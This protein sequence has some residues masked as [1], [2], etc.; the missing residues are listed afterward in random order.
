MHAEEIS[1]INGAD[2]KK[3]SHVLRFL[4]TQHWF[5]EVAPDTFAHNMLSS[6]IDTGKN[7]TD[8]FA[9]TK[10]KGTS[11]L[12]ALV[13]FWADEGVKAGSYFTE[14]LVDP[15][16]SHSEE[17]NEAALQ[18]G[19]GTSKSMWEYYD[20]PEGRVRGDRFD[21]FMTGFNTLQPP[22][23]ILKTFDWNTIPDG[24]LLVDVG[25]GLGHV[26]LEVGKVHPN[27]HVV[28]EDREIVLTK[29]KLFW[30]ENLPSYVSEEKVHFITANFFDEQPTLPGEPGVFLLRNIT[31]DWSDKYAIKILRRLRDAATPSTKLV[32]ISCITDYACRLPNDEAEA[33]PAPLLANF[34]GANIFPYSFDLSMLGFFNAKERTHQDHVEILDS[35][36]WKLSEVRRNPSRKE[37]LSSIIAVPAEQKA[38]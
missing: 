23:D 27:V 37:F 4:A 2:P 16:T 10:H 14:I 19:L 3:L 25:G 17:A 11:G 26:S 31:H 32:I 8:D 30:E 36:G 29:A 28:I 38:Q 21:V 33:P 5:R 20:T 9:T 12:A 1:K 7:V 6:L 35:A 24:H 34:G 13:G 18:R 22:M 15:K